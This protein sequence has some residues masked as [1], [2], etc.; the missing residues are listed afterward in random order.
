MK[1]LRIAALLIA[2]FLLLSSATTTVF[3]YPAPAP[4]PASDTLGCD[5]KCTN[6]CSRSGWKDR[7]LK[8]CGI[9]CGKCKGCVPSGPYA[10][11]AECPCYRD[12]KNPKGRDK[13]P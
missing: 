10:D 7:C 11:K 5:K 6:R 8:Y 3:G 9:C 4:A 13:C 2:T 1:Q 12:L